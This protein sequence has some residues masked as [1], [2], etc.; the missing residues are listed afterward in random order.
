MAIIN[1]TSLEAW[2]SGPNNEHVKWNFKYERFLKVCAFPFRNCN[3]AVGFLL[4]TFAIISV[5]NRALRET[6]I[7]QW[8]SE[9]PYSWA[10]TSFTLK[11][12]TFNQCPVEVG[13]TYVL[14]RY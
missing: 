8:E 14:G 7:F 1:V 10:P 3:S 6:S 9:M 12:L 5:H 4:R 13:E 11:R 2:G